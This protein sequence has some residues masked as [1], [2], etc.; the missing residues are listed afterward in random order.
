VVF[1]KVHDRG[2]HFAALEQ[3]ELLWED[4]QAFVKK[5]WKV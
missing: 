5:V 4:V 3:P 1:Y 2:G